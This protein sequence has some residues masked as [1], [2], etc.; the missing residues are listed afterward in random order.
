[1]PLKKIAGNHQYENALAALS[2]N[3]SRIT[4]FDEEIKNQ[5]LFLKD[6]LEYQALQIDQ[7][8]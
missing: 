7:K 3:P 6:F 4:I 5:D 8:N 1:M 2:E